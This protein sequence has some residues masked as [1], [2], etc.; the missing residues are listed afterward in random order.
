MKICIVSP[1]F[2]PEIGGPATYTYELARGLQKRGHTVEVVTLSDADVV[3]PRGVEV[4]RVKQS[5]TLGTISRQAVLLTKV[6]RVGNRCGI[7]YAQ[8]PEVVGFA[9]VIAG[10]ILRKPVAV[11]YV[12][13]IAWEKA[14]GDGATDKFLEDFLDK[15]ESGFE[16]RLIKKIQNFVLNSANNIITPSNYLGSLVS[17]NYTHNNNK[18]TIV[19]NAVDLEKINNI[20][21]RG[22]F[23]EPGVVTV[24]R[25][26]P[27][28][29]IDQLIE[30]VPELS[31]KYPEFK[32][33]IIGDGQ[34]RAKLESRAASLS[35]TDKVE[36]MGAVKH[37]T[38]IRRLKEADLFVLNS[39]YEG[40]PHVVIESMASRTPVLATDISGTDELIQNGE[41]GFL[42]NIESNISEEIERVLESESDK[43]IENAYRS[44]E[45]HYT[46]ENLIQE[47]EQV[48]ESIK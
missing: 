36:F 5:T 27:W 18:T 14:F 23:G 25:L 40:L 2:P 42:M 24:G 21:G 7:I 34:E 8:D 16:Y 38:V 39:V 29:R 46:W 20:E 45:K 43:S 17:K 22:R 26:V 19:R 11:K 4:H 30:A 9:S 10:K 32:L 48:L 12:G 1:L 35:I 3:Q 15:P 28:K 41:T 37:E 44:V 6:V 33:I 47:T 31:T 13:D